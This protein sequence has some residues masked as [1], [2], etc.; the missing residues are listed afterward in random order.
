MEKEKEVL[1]LS[2]LGRGGFTLP[3]S[4]YTVGMKF[5]L[6]SLSYNVG[7][8]EAIKTGVQWGRGGTQAIWHLQ[9]SGAVADTG[10]A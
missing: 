1:A 3:W 7:A 6:Q 4:R 10:L 5:P 2:S 8:I 9:Q